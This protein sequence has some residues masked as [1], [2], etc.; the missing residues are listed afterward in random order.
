MDDVA[1][2]VADHLITRFG[3]G[4]DGGLVGHGAGR[5]E[6]RGLLPEQSG[7]SVL[8]LDYGRVVAQDIVPDFGLAHDATHLR[9]RPGNGVAAEVDDRFGHGWPL[10]REEW[11]CKPCSW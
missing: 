6:A 8:K 4:P 7:D 10:I 9:R 2:L 1:V 3:V 11:E 5:H